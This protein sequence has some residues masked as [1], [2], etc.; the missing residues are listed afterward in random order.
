MRIV[1]LATYPARAGAGQAAYRIHA[2]LRA[3]GLDSWLVGEEPV[4]G[5][6]R[7]VTPSRPRWGNARRLLRPLVANWRVPRNARGLFSELVLPGAAART[8]AAL[9]PDVVHVHWVQ[10]GLLSLGQLAAL[11]QPLVWT[12]HDDWAFTGGCHYAGACQRYEQSCGCCPLL[13]AHRERDASARGL[14]AKQRQFGGHAIRWV[15]ISEAQRAR[16]ARAALLRDQPLAFIQCAI[17]TEEF[18]PHPRPLARR[19]LGLEENRF[20]ILAIA[21]RLDDPRKG[22]DRLLA[23]LPQIPIAGEIPPS[24]LLVGS[25]PEMSV[26]AGWHVRR[27]GV[28][29]DSVSRALAYSAADVCVV[30]SR[31]DAGPMTT[32]EALA[33]GTPVVATPCGLNPEV[34][35]PERNGWIAATGAPAELAAGIAW[36]RRT[37]RVENVRA[38]ARTAV[39]ARSSE[40]EAAAYAA[41]Y[42]TA[43]ASP[44]PGSGA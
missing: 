36:A 3:H 29:H 28:L 39:V 37:V 40:I 10:D 35:A 24:L 26:P 33:C 8:V 16:A 38:A 22:Y 2:A 34:I 17:R 25:G 7:V 18:Q 11:R 23:A 19:L 13:G 20:W 1:H 14:A 21:S 15:A 27:L 41:L 42:A 12:L 30:P 32:L 44:Q 5:D 31:E 9:R 4:P 6:E 43:L